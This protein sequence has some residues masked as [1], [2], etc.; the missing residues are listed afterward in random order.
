LKSIVLLSSGLDSTVNFLMALRETKILLSLTFDYGQKAREREI[1]FSKKICER[2]KVPHKVIYLDFLREINKSALGDKGNIPL[3]SESDF[4]KEEI[5]RETAQAVWVPN[6]NGLFLNIAAC[7]AESLEADLIV[8][9]FNREEAQT[10]PD[11]SKEFLTE[12]NKFFT[13][14]TLRKPKVISYTQD[15]N[16]KELVEKGI[17]LGLPFELIWSCYLGEELMC[18]TCESCQ[19]LWRATEGTPAHN[20][21]RERMRKCLR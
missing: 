3:L 19:R 16:K 5:L 18:G 8:T 1:Y 15:L 2:Y 17:G 4:S 6:R 11:N 10:F 13:Y 21:V 9:G 12:A 20:I 7:F 14:S